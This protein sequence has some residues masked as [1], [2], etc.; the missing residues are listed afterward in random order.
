MPAA[1]PCPGRRPRHLVGGGGDPVRV[2]GVGPGNGLKGRPLHHQA[3]FVSKMNF[4]KNNNKS[5]DRLK[6][7]GKF[8]L[9]YIQYT[10]RGERRTT[11]WLTV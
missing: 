4:F 10:E 7:R 5:I 8:K 6:E 9:Q 2:D 1:D 3:I 11:V